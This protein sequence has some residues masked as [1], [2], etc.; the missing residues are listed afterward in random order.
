[1]VIQRDVGV[2]TAVVRIAFITDYRMCAREKTF[3]GVSS[4]LKIQRKLGGTSESDII[5]NA[6]RKFLL[7]SVNQNTG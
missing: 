5:P 1:M 6:G 3:A 2:T 7:V 4:V